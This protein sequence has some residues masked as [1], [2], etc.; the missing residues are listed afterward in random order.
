[1][2]DLEKLN[3][4]FIW[5]ERQIGDILYRITS[6]LTRSLYYCYQLKGDSWVKIGK[7]ANPTKLYPVEDVNKRV[8]RLKNG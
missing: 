1:M 8:R 7:N 4:Q 2:V 3:G 5:E 6:N